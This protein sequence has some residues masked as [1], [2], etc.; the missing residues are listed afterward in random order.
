M[1]KGIPNAKYTGEFKQA[2]I[3]GMRREG[4]SQNEVAARN[5]V[6]RLGFS[7]GSGYIS[8]KDRKVCILSGGA[9]AL[10]SGSRN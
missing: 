2:G 6:P 10:R 5:N 4:L 9:V 8:R 1:P 3:E 7:H